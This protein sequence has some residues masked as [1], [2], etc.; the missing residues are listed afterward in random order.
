[1][2]VKATEGSARL[3]DL[4]NGAVHQVARFYAAAEATIH[5]C[6]VDASA[7]RTRLTINGKVVQVLSRR[8]GGAWQTD[9]KP[10][11][12]ED[13]AVVIFV[14]F[15]PDTPA[16]YVVPAKQAQDGIEARQQQL[17]DRHGGER[18]RNPDTNHAEIKLEHVHQWCDRWDLLG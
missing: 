3:Q 15:A 13:A 6:R 11:I 2:N 16:F 7:P 10:P 4:S 12:I 14:D 1:M 18:P 9:R 5:G 8:K 17:K